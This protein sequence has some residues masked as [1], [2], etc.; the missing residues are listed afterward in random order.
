MGRSHGGG[1]RNPARIHAARGRGG[2]PLCK[3]RWNARTVRNVLMK[4][5][6]ANPTRQHGGT[7]P[8]RWIVNAHRA[9][10]KGKGS[11]VRTGIQR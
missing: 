10:H 5:A 1:V 4:E 3:W 11:A 2:Q 7:P 6:Q 8:L 9:Q